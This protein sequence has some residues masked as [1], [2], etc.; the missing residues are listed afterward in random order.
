MTLDIDQEITD[1]AT[2]IFLRHF[3]SKAPISSVNPLVDIRQDIDILLSYWAISKPVQVFL[4]YLL[5]HRH[6]A[7]ALLQ[8]QQHSDDAVVRGRIDARS[9]IMARRTTGNPALIISHDGIRSFDTGP[10][11]IVAWVVQMVAIHSASLYALQPDTSKYLP[12]I[13]SV[14]ETVSAVRRLDVVR[15]Q[16]KHVSLGRRPGINAIRDAS[17]SRRALYRLAI[18]AYRTLTEIE[19]GNQN[20]LAEILHNALLGPLEE[21]RRF[22]LAVAL[23]VGEVISTETR[24]PLIFSIID[25]QQDN[26]ILKCGP[27]SIYWQS[28]RRYLSQPDLERSEL[29]VKHIL[30]AYGIAMGSD[31]PD[32][33]VT[34]DEVGE[35]ISII[36]VKYLAGDTT[37]ARFREAANQIVRYARGYKYRRKIP[38]LIGNSLIALSLNAPKMTSA[39][40]STLV[41]TSVDFS[42][43]KEGKLADWVKS[44]VLT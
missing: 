2:R 33:V 21:W 41:P 4:K 13:R 16:S 15:E 26:P 39:A 10:N 34:N 8:F 18:D 24:K 35:V 14:V 20:T 38:S 43:V 30:N 36:E 9:T 11:Q 22:E 3:L 40:K 28:A 44:K 29:C 1:F 27:F 19:A 25:A 23:G 6:E 42:G 12:T 7:Q 31:R 5:S 32:I 37:N 17:R